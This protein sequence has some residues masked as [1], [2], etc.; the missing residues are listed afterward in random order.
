MYAFFIRRPIVAICIA[1]I[2]LLGGIFAALSL[3]IA[4]YPDIVPPEIQI[5]TSYPG[6]DCFT[7]VDAVASPIEQQMSG[8]D[9]MDYMTSTST[10]DGAMSLSILFEVGSEP[11]MDQVLS[12]LRYAEANAQL[13]AEVDA[14]G[15]RLRKVS[16]P[17]ML[18]YALTAPDGEYDENWMANYANINLVNPLLRVPGVGNV[19]VMGAG[20]YAMRVWLQPAKLAA[21]GITVPEVVAAIKA[22]NAVNPVGKIGAE[23]AVPGQQTTYTVRA[24]GRLSTPEEFKNIIVRADAGAIIRLKD[25]ARVDLGSN[26]Y[27]TKSRYN[28]RP[29]AI[30][31]IYQS[32]GSNALDTV[33]AVEKTLKGYPTPPGLNLTLALN[34]TESVRLGINEIVTTL[35]T[36]LI[37]VMFVVFVFL[38][39]WRSTIIPLAAVPVSIIGAF[40]AL[41]ALGMNINTVCLMGLVL[42]IGLVVDD[43]IVVVEAV[44]N[45]VDRGEEPHA[46]TLA[47]MKEVAGPVVA[48]A[49]V[50]SAVFF[51]SMLLPGIGGLLFKQFAVTIGV[52]IVLSAFNALSLSPA[53]AALLL[54]A[55]PKT[56]RSPLAR[57]GARFDAG[58]DRL[59]GWYARIS[60]GMIRKS[61]WTGLALAAVAASLLPMGAAVPPGFLP[62][63]DEGYFYGTLQ[64]PYGSSLGVTE[65][66]SEKVEGLLLGH[67]GVRGL[68]TVAGFNMMTGV[69]SPN[70]SFFF[71][72]LDSWKQRDKP[73]LSA[74][75]LSMN[76]RARMR[77]DIPEAVGFSMTPPPIPGVG[78]SSDIT[79]MIE[80]RANRGEDYL[81]QQTAAF[82]EAAMRRPEIMTIDN[83]MAPSTPQYFLALDEDKAALLGVNIAEA[84]QTLQTFLGSLFV[85]YFNSYG[86][87][88]QVYVQADAPARMNLSGLHEL[89]LSGRDGERVPLDALVTTRPILGPDFLIRQ[90]M[91]NASMLDIVASAG[92]PASRAME[93]V[94]EVFEQTMPSDMGYSYTGMSYQ[95]QKE[96]EGIG[97]GTLFAISSVFIF[98][99]LASLYESWS[100]PLAVLL[101][102]PVAVAG[103]LATLLLTKLDMNLY[104]EI[105][106]IMLIAL[107]AKNAILIVRFGIDRI[108][109]GDSVLTATLA[110]AKVRLRPILMTSFAFTLGCVPL[111]LASGAGAAARQVIG[112][113]VIGGMLAATFI[114]VFF[115]PFAFYV[116]AKRR[117]WNVAA[118][119]NS[120]ASPAA[121]NPIGQSANTPAV[122]TAS[123]SAGA[124]M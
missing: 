43:A 105:G 73:G 47:A 35:I 106:L 103:A 124:S 54:R 33:A 78:A 97:T 31:A 98:L 34:T 10:N 64:L 19:E 90:N 85:N 37:L 48:T 86:Y 59:R 57:A 53:L 1:L 27:A 22:Q 93:A 24:Q 56:R 68:V 72:D 39:G 99:I 76:L 113:A 58:F 51:P 7:V 111:A 45:H 116:I 13:P 8:V 44:Q 71:V 20:E 121:A 112:T 16:G 23:P 26:S 80:D 100:L 70:N 41:A 2:T 46:A 114:G 123:G 36:A 3:P 11:N 14:M 75:E 95:Q 32:P 102:V 88:W 87:Q 38:H 17:P 109:E 92:T 96:A 67:P 120:A 117:K 65:Q 9:G 122:G 60:N 81:V 29:C 49:L 40:V 61:V 119:G 5:T 82:T 21:L 62:D 15:V 107:A 74:R 89:Y 63:E 110:A 79:L 42:A 69:Q 101:S 84:Y 18:L 52:S 30:V 66:A 94:E 108:N 83:F 118:A 6:A 77:A 12:Y 25:V 115:L 4:Q 104:A 50:L 28:G 91:Y 55:A